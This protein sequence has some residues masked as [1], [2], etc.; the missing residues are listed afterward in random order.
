MYLLSHQLKVWFGA[1]CVACTAPEN[2]VRYVGAFD[3]A[4]RNASTQI[5]VDTSMSVLSKYSSQPLSYDPLKSLS[6]K[7]RFET[8]K[9]TNKKTGPDQQ[10]VY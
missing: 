1:Q 2:C 10:V 3:T 5:G 6:F 4:V 7:C 9:T 8:T